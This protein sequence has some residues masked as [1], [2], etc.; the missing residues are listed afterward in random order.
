MG[1]VRY[2]SLVKYYQRLY[3]EARRRD[4]PLIARVIVRTVRLRGGRF[5]KKDSNAKYWKDVGNQ[6]SCFWTYDSFVAL[7]TKCLR[8]VW[9]C[10]F[11]LQRAREKTS[12]A[13]REGAPD[14]RTPSGEQG[15][16][17]MKNAKKSNQG[18][19]VSGECLAEI[20]V[21]SSEDLEIERAPTVKRPRVSLEDFAAI[22]TTSS[23]S[24]QLSDNDRA[25]PQY[26]IASGD[27]DDSG[28]DQSISRSPR[29]PRLFI[30]KQRLMQSGVSNDAN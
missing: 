9:E 22:V 26:R 28:S 25:S 12:Q 23:S 2:R 27:D 17:K 7:S 6:V 15:S 30:L 14:L 4:K 11:N 21:E 5:L 8:L 18:L 10:D 29:G 20:Q 13:L 19:P 24:S 1:N 16:R 3:L